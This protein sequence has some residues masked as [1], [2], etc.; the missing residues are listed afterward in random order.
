MAQRLLSLNPQSVRQSYAQDSENRQGPL[1]CTQL[2]ELV[3]VFPNPPSAPPSPGQSSSLSRQS[4]DSAYSSLGAAALSSG[5]SHNLDRWEWPGGSSTDEDSEQNQWF[6][7]RTILSPSHIQRDTQF[8]S[9]ALIGLTLRTHPLRDHL[10]RPSFRQLHRLSTNFSPRSFHTLSTS[11]SSGSMPTHVHLATPIPNAR[12][13]IP[14]L[15]FI[16][17]F[18]SVDESTVH[19]LTHT[20]PHSL[21]FPGD[22]IMSD[23][24]LLAS[25]RDEND[26]APG[27]LAPLLEF[28]EESST[29]SKL[30]TGHAVSCDYENALIAPLF[31]FS[32]DRLSNLWGYIHGFVKKRSSVNCGRL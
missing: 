10:S 25:Q 14:F 15:S 20:S 29:Y 13:Q 1:T 21:L 4:R 17:Y 6:S 12:I 30:R 16:L 22:E 26:T 19:L 3:Y 27:V 7:T 31:G 23:P 32:L 24:H 18:L 9:Q 5:T 28:D 11:S 8:F 2:A